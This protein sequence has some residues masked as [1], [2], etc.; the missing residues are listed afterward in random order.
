VRPNFIRNF[1]TL[2]PAKRQVRDEA[3]DLQTEDV[4][5]GQDYHSLRVMV[6][7][8]TAMIE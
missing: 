8:H 2:P 3:P 6:I 7:K 5:P 1:L 4:L